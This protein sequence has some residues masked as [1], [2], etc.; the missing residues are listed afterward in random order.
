MLKMNGL[1]GELI[2]FV[3]I[4]LIIVIAVIVVKRSGRK[5]DS[6]EGDTTKHGAGPENPATNFQKNSQN[7][8]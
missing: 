1:Y 2:L 7:K 5:P 8:K 3:V 6:E 4:V